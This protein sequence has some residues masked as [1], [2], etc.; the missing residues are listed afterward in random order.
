[1]NRQYINDHYPDLT[2]LDGF[3]D[4]IIGVAERIDLVAVCY[5]YAKIIAQLMQDMTE[6]DA[7][8]YFDFNILGAYV[9]EHTPIFL[10]TEGD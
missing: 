4:A 9:G 5:D 7:I 6:E 10:T 8:E 2:V 3:D 1:M